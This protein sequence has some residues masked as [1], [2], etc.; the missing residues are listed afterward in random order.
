[1]RLCYKIV[2]GSTVHRAD[3]DAVFEGK[4]LGVWCV[5]MDGDWSKDLA[6]NKKEQ[7]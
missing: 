7:G 1:M 2:D 6:K 3:S 4:V 5:E